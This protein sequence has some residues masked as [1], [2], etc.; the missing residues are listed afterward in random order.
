MEEKKR[1]GCLTL[2]LGFSIFTYLLVAFSTLFQTASFHELQPRYPI[3]SIYLLGALS[4][5][6]IGFMIALFQ[7]KKWAFWGF[8]VSNIVQFVLNLSVGDNLSTSLIGLTNILVMYGILQIGKENK[9]WP[10]LA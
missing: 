9:G 5:L 3:V 2:W 7:W 1:H 4:I 6:N 10:Q 8:C